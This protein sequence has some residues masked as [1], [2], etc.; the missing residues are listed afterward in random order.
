MRYKGKFLEAILPAVTNPDD[1]L[2][3]ANELERSSPRSTTYHEKP[4]HG[5]IAELAASALRER[6]TE[7]TT[8][9]QL[10]K[11]L[12]TSGRPGPNQRTAALF[13]EAA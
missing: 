12:R 13:D 1:I 3:I 2:T 7:A 6:I 4:H 8:R 11:S 10:E 5:G 9:V